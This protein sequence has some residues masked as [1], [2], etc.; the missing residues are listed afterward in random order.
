MTYY[1]YIGTYSQGED[2]GIFRIGLGE[3]GIEILGNTQAVNP[4]Y[5]CRFGGWLLAVSETQSYQ[6]RNGGAALSF[7]VGPHGEL[8]EI[9]RQGVLGRDPCHIVGLGERVYTANYSEGTATA[10]GFQ[11]GRFSPTLQVLPHWGKGADPARQEMAHIHCV[12]PTPDGNLAMC[13]LGT[14]QVAVYTPAF[15]RVSAVSLPAGS[16]PRHIVFG[17][18]WAYVIAEL[19]SR[20]FVYGYR[21]GVLAYQ[22]D[23]PLL[24]ADFT[25]FSNGA[26][27]KISPCG[28]FLVCSNRG[29]NSLTSFRVLEGG[30][31]EFWERV[32]CGGDF[33]RDFAYT[34]DGKFLLCA[35]Q[36]SD[37][38]T[39]FQVGEEGRL[40][41]TGLSCRLPAP[42]CVLFD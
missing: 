19:S 16:G 40:T 26:A 25:G 38:L 22:G 6:G 24:P 34:P 14:D 2:G 5:L 42:V 20:V 41:E 37:S 30:G 27:V 23:Y 7:S 8:E 39:L 10:L 17:G 33:P 35:N 9:S 1:G 4:S 12:V 18:N 31:L 36:K 32:P 28:R 29:H 11:Q 21:D 13:D 15:Q 3:K